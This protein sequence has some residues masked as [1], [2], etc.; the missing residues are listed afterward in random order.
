MVFN[1]TLKKIQYLF[2]LDNLVAEPSLAFPPSDGPFAFV[3]SFL[4]RMVAG[5]RA[6]TCW[7]PFSISQAD[8]QFRFWVTW[9]EERESKNL[10]LKEPLN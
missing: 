9:R 8:R 7:I 5:V 3:E 1:C 4:S 6:N 10:P 2:P